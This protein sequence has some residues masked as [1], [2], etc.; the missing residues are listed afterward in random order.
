[1]SGWGK[2]LILVLSIAGVLLWAAEGDGPFRPKPAADYASHQTISGVTVGAETYE[3]EELIKPAFGKLNPYEHGVLP[4]LVVI[5]NK[6]KVAIR[7]DH[8]QV[9]YVTPE[10]EKIDSTP[11][12]DLPYLQGPRQPNMAPTP[13]P[14]PRRKPKNALADP[15]LEVRAF[16]AKMLPPGE[17]AS[18][19]FYFQTGNRM[20]SQLY[21][22]GLRDA[23]TNQDLF[24]FEIPLEH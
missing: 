7:L 22:S 2:G 5:E 10:R 14:F 17:T 4:V 13:L 12:K 19:F 3:R 8:L 20:R 21:V 1:M 16:A 24:Y 15:S 6:G 9:Q 11:S 18:G 23:S